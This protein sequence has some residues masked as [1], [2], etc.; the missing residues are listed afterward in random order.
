M[1]K[2]PLILFAAGG[3]GGHIYP[4][5]AIA[6]EIKRQHPN[7]DIVF[8]G[9]PMGLESKIVPKAGYPLNKIHIGRL[10]KNVSLVERLKTLI[11]LP[12]S[13]IESA[14][15]VLKH[16]PKAVVGVGGYATGPVLLM[17][18]LLGYKTFAWEPNAYPG[19][20]NRLLAK[21]VTWSLV[22]FEEA[23]KILGVKN[24]KIVGYPLR[25][26]FGSKSKKERDNSS[27]NLL[28]FG[29]SQGARAINEIMKQLYSQEAFWKMNIQVVHQTG[30]HD[31]ESVK[32][33]QSHLAPEH[34]SRVEILPFIENMVERY[35]WADLAI[36]RAGMGT[37]AELAAMS[38]PAVFIPLPTAADNHQFKN[39]KALVDINASRLMEQKDA[40][41]ETLLSQIREIYQD[42]KLLKNMSDQMYKINRDNATQ[43]IVDLIL[44][45]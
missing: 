14:F 25:S 26:G 6:D 27:M 32:N 15:I 8:V 38:V 29:G 4:A 16:R 35:E 28:V 31:F 36:C 1:K 41:A 17:A 34:K 45:T 43:E 44:K 18:A 12:W 24:Y 20:A 9:T 21:F 40:S 11:L 33:V 3:T 5:V 7:Y 13:L 19:L 2:N 39:A 22:M 42:R 37:V 30:P 23:A 10:N